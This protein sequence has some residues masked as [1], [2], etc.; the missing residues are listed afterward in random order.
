MLRFRMRYALIASVFLLATLQA[1]NQEKEITSADEDKEFCAMYKRMC[2]ADP[3]YEYSLKGCVEFA[4]N[5]DLFWNQQ[6]RCTKCFSEGAKRKATRK[7]KR[8]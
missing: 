8:E 3:S 5:S 6:K 4:R 2:V 1:E 7:K